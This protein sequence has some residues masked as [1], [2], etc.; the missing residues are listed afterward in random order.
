MKVYNKEAKKSKISGR[1]VEWQT[2]RSQKPLEI[3]LRGGSTPPLPT[4]NNKVDN[5]K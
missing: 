4:T 3:T 5:Q 1:V 2:R